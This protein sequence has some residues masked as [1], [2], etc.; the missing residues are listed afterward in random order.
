M[1]R[2][3]LLVELKLICQP[4]KYREHVRRRFI[5]EQIMHYLEGIKELCCIDYVIFITRGFYHESMSRMISREP[6][7]ESPV[8]GRIAGQD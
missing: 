4:A 3:P 7:L 8:L 5:L 1:K 2:Y 6:R